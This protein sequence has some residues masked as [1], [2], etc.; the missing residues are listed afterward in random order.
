MWRLGKSLWRQIETLNESA[1]DVQGSLLDFDVM[2]TARKQGQ[3]TK[4]EI[5]FPPGDGA[6]T[7]R[8]QMSAEQ[9]QSLDDGVD[10]FFKSAE[11]SL[12]KPMTVMDWNSLLAQ[13]GY[14][15]VGGWMNQ[16]PQQSYGQVQ[17][18]VS[19]GFAKASNQLVGPRSLEILL[20]L[21]C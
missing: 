3:G 18:A 8:K 5:S 20:N 13:V 19:N 2:V 11:Y 12:C 1:G 9:L 10:Y 4:M 6:F 16:L 15:V 21:P 14:D 17:K 7:F